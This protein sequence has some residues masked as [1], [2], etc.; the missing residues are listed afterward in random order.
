MIG[1]IQASNPGRLW[2]M[3]MGTRGLL[4]VLFSFVAVGV[5][6]SFVYRSCESGWVALRQ[7]RR[8]E[9]RG[10]HEKASQ[11]YLRAV[12]NGVPQDMV[13]HRILHLYQSTGNSSFLQPLKIL[14][15]G[16]KGEGVGPA[17]EMIA[18]AEYSMGDY[19][20]SSRTY[21]LAAEVHPGRKHLHVK[22]ARSLFF[23]GRPEEA[24][25]SYQLFFEKK[26]VNADAAM[27]R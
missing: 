3:I 11:E 2:N 17:L 18:D 8:L 25:E 27:P 6:T 22:R 16:E 26:E 13:I 19:M 21:G 5:V 4:W 15:A 7:A 23:A 1:L 14:V 9:R 12:R 24:V 10:L 20:E